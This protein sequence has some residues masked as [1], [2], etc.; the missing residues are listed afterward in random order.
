MLIDE[1]ANR[2]KALNLYRI[3]VYQNGQ[4]D[5]QELRESNRVCNV[6]S[7][8]KSVTSL[9]VGSVAS[10]LQL[11][12]EQN[13]RTLLGEEWDPAWPDVWSRITLGDVM[14]HTTGFGAEE[15]DI[16]HPD[17]MLP[18]D[19]NFLNKV[20]RQPI[21]YQPGTKMVYTDANYYLVS[22]ILSAQTGMRLQDL[23]REELFTPMGMYGIGWAT[24]P[25][26]YA[27]GAT[28]LFLSVQDMAK[29]GILILQHGQWEGRQLVSSQWLDLATAPH[30]SPEDSDAKYGYGFWSRRS[31]NAIIANGMLGQVIYIFPSSGRVVAWQACTEAPAMGLLTQYLQDN[32]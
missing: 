13:V 18:P 31:S 12:L 11:S 30:A 28:G 8:S 22:R 20:M 6:Y 29:I 4:Y 25:F 16:D 9:V 14:S 32:G 21:V 27:M 1:L 26:G 2:A 7:V 23:A 24:C 19:R 3:C 17:F 10:Q 15:L 5:T